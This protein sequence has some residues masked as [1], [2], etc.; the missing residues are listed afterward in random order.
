[1]FRL[2]M[3][4]VVQE[5]ILLSHSAEV[6][7][8][9]CRKLHSNLQ[10]Y[11]G[12]KMKL[13]AQSV[14]FMAIF[15]TLYY[16]L[17]IFSPYVPAIG[18]PEIKISLEALV[19]TIFG[20]VL[21]P[22][23]GALTAFIGAFVTWILPPG[24]PS[25]YGA[26]FLLSPPINAFVVGLIY[27]KKWKAAFATFSIL[28]VAFLFLPPS[29]PL[30]ENLY[31]GVAVIW[32]KLIALFLI[33]PTVL[34]AR[35]SLSKIQ[36]IGLSTAVA[37]VMSVTAVYTCIQPEF[38]DLN[39][40]FIF[41]ALASW[42]IFVV[43]ILIVKGV[44]FSE[45]AVTVGL[46]YFLLAFIGNQADNMWGSDVFAVP[47]VYEGIFGLPLD[48]VRFL[49]IVSPFVYPAIRLIQAIIATAIAAPLMEALKNM[50]WFLKEETVESS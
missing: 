16:V 47:A 3:Y 20:L 4:V 23:L 45:K 50:A 17:S 36:A 28:I 10:N 26:P 31:V 42:I 18:L 38:S 48:A 25:L 24:S 37:V 12:G 49:F 46:L 13:S 8:T 32:D 1:M 19:A 39:I 35:K 7:L 2:F 11:T 5:T 15:A 14:A 27:Y 9:L 22:Y 41:A 21:G 34:I 40:V 33:I 30:P 29:Q 6:L 43:T 44:V